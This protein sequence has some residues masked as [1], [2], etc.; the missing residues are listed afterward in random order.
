PSSGGPASTPASGATSAPKPAATTGTA[1]AGAA[2]PTQAGA[3]QR[4]VQ[5]CGNQTI[6]VNALQGEPDNIDPNKSSFATESAVIS[7]V[8]QPLMTFHKDL[9]PHPP[10][11]NA[12]AR[13]GT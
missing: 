11:A 13:S 1:G 2:Q 12:F 7:R 6:S 5:P 4:N 3:A 9:K 10:A 8:F